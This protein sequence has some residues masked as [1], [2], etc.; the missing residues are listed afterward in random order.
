MPKSPPHYERPGMCACLGKNRSSEYELQKRGT[1]LSLDCLFRRRNTK[2][3]QG[4]QIASHNERSGRNSS[5]IGFIL[6]I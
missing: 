6:L 4:K 2:S 3:N 5:N 1:D